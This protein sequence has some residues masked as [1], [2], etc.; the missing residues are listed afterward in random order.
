MT[1]TDEGKVTCDHCGKVM[2][3]NEYCWQIFTQ[4][5]YI[6]PPAEDGD[7]FE[8]YEHETTRHLCDACVDIFDSIPQDEKGL[9][10]V[11]E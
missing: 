7:Y 6:H 3:V 9:L 2:P 8:P 4:A 11:L 10:K 1:K 5:G